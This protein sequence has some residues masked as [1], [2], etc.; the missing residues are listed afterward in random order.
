MEFFSGDRRTACPFCFL[1]ETP[2]LAE[3]NDRTRK[4]NRRRSR[5]RIY[6][7]L[8]AIAKDQQLH[9]VGISRMR[10]ERFDA[11][12]HR[13]LLKLFANVFRHSGRFC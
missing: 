7:N 10:F 4:S 3:R 9:G 5:V 8:E 6:G 2:Y 12:V 1:E 13:S 11:G